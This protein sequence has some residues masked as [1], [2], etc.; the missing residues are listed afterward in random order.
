MV[1][2]NWF[3][4]SFN[5]LSWKRSRKTETRQAPEENQPIGKTVV[6][7]QPIV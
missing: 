1:K 4:L 3:L 7:R 2:L 6:K 5:N